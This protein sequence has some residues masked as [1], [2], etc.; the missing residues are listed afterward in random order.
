LDSA[1]NALKKSRLFHTTAPEDQVAEEA[2]EYKPVKPSLT[3]KL[4]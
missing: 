2:D 1:L 4:K 3:E